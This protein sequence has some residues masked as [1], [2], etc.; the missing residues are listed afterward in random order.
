[1]KAVLFCEHAY[2]FGILEPLRDALRKN[3]HD[4]LWFTT[5]KLAPAFPFTDEQHTDSMAELR[6]FKSDAL[7]I[8]GNYSPFYIRGYKV[9]VFHGL[10]GEKASHFKVRGYF[11][12]YLTQGP[13]FTRRFEELKAKYRNFEVIETGWSKLDIYEKNKEAYLAERQRLLD[14]H[15]A[16]TIVLFAPTHNVSMNGAPFLEGEF[17]RLAE[18]RDYL[19]VVKFHDL[20]QP[21]VVERYRQMAAR[22]PNLILS[23]DPSISQLIYIADVMVSDTSSVVY[24]FLLL[25]KPVITYRSKAQ[26]IIWDD[27]SEY[28]GLGEAVEENLSR[29]PFRD[30]RAE[31]I[32][33]Y[34]PYHDGKSS[35]R[36]IEAVEKQ[37]ALHG[38]PAW[39]SMGIDR[40]VESLKIF[41][42][43]NR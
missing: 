24:E 10:A 16:K 37:I 34:H 25:D 22:I 23:D 30:R 4:Y 35:E 7:F 6:R 43:K 20:T 39:R 11:D 29:D 40:M 5:K 19:I 15:Q 17:E 41:N 3:G 2:A 33:E 42:I 14:T 32:A 26:R 8:P 9:Q 38:V 36:M 1:M 18:N 13:Y 27:R 28:E 21:G 12:L 31:I